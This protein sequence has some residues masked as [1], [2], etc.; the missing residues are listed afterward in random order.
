MDLGE[1]NALLAIEVGNAEVGAEGVVRLGV[2]RH[3]HELQAHVDYVAAGRLARGGLD[4]DAHDQARDGC[5][6]VG[7]VQVVEGGPARA[8]D[9][10]GVAVLQGGHA[11]DQVVVGQASRQARAGRVAQAVGAERVAGG[12][13]AVGTAANQVEREGLGARLR[14]PPGVGQKRDRLL[15]GHAVGREGRVVGDEAGEAEGARVLDCLA[16]VHAFLPSSSV[17]RRPVR[18]ALPTVPNVAGANRMW[19][20]PIVAAACR[21]HFSVGQTLTPQH[22]CV[23]WFPVEKDGGSRPARA[24]G[25]THG[26]G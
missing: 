6:D 2:G 18:A 1:G 11:T 5:L 3:A 19:A 15:V 16:Q 4:V 23:R 17:V 7:D 9:L 10:G 8:G 14:L 22:P 26:S 24:T 25:G 21:E 13:V 20:A 12:A